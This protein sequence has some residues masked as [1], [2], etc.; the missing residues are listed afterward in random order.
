M[1]LDISILFYVLVILAQYNIQDAL[2]SKKI[3][4][5]LNATAEQPPR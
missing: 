3:Y 1:H 4:Q 5:L 2:N